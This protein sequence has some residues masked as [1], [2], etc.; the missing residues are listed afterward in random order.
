MRSRAQ[1]SVH[2]C[3]QGLCLL[4]AALLLAAPAQAHKSSDSYLTLDVRQGQ[5]QQGRID[6]QWDI[7]LRDLDMAIGLDQDGNGELTWNEVKARHE[8]IAAYALA[9]LKLANGGAACPLRVTEQLLDD[10]SDGAYAVL[11]LRAD[12]GAP[13]TTLDVDYRL[14]FDIDP[15]HKGLLQLRHGAQASTAIFAP[16]SAHQSLRVADASAWRQF[17]DYVRHGVWHIWIGFDH[18]LFL[19]SL[20]LPAV[21]VYRDRR[22]EGRSTFRAAAL[23]VLKIVTAFTLAHSITLTL[24]ALGVV[25]LPSRVVE[26][27]IAASVALAALNNVWPLFHGRR[28]LVAFAFGLIHGFGFASVLLDLGLPRSALL[29][30]LV[31]FNVG[32]ELGQLAIVLLFLPLAFL[33][34]NTV[35]Y[36]RGVLGAGSCLIVLL[37]LAWLVERSLDVKLLA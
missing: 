10:H 12:C 29:L 6:G 19:L 32:V 16:D 31:G 4:A 14:L 2:T 20:L 15:Q 37:A 27:A 18:I 23:D 21:L 9:R 25:A 30:S 13:V 5:A 11:R 1:R 7:A 34:R 24:A 28:A 36:R 33:A 26:S 35:L 3:L 8:A 17:G 22:W